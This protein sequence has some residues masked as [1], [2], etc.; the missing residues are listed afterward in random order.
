VPDAKHLEFSFTIPFGAVAEFYLPFADEVVFK[1]K[2]NPLF[3][4]VRNSVCYLD[5]GEYSVSYETN[6]YLRRI[7]ST[8]NTIRELLADRK[9][10][11]LLKKMM[12]QM[13]QMPSSMLDFTMRQVTAK[14]GTV[15]MAKKMDMLDKTLA[16]FE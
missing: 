4:D 16:E 15:D 8:H 9:A 3:T 5:A 1:D 11:A 14:Y 6:K 7:L 13:N 10:K 12:P 2:T